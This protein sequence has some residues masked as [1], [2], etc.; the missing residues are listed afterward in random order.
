MNIHS[1]VYVSGHDGLV[2]SA[3]LR[4]L[5]RAGLRNVLTRTRARLDLTR[6]DAV[7]RFF[8]R[9]RP[10]YV[11]HAAALVGGIQAN[12]QRPGDFIYQ[13]LAMQTNVIE[14]CRRH[15]VKRMIFFGSSCAYP[16]QAKVPIREDQILAGPIEPTNEPYAVA[17]I[18]GIR[19]CQAY[20]QQYGTDFV[21][22]IPA[23][24]YGPQ[25]HFDDS[26]HVTAGLIRKFHAARLAGAAAVTLWGTGRPKR[27][28]LFVDDLAQ[29][30]LLLMRRRLRHDIFNVGSGQETS[31]AELA[32]L[33]SQVVGYKG[34]IDFD[35][36]RPDG[37]P[38]RS[39]DNRRIAAL[40]WRPKTELTDGLRLTY[41]WFRRTLA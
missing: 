9:S 5:G 26:G 21:T 22:V 23:N 24:L 40:G 34:R 31:I 38:R 7:E 1:R 29:A 18:A 16:K 37:I 32:A 30:C 35:A 36:S 4:T 14:A 12:Q 39:L 20:N 11:F 10:E 2:G 28:F 27:D 3:L 13:N 19:L 41:Y 25:D 15:R 17:K 33:V 8:S 6:Q